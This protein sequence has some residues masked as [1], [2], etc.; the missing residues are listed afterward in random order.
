MAPADAASTGRPV[1]IINSATS[2]RCR[3]YSRFALFLFSDGMDYRGIGESR[4][5][6]LRDFGAGWIDWGALDFEAVLRHAER[7]YSDRSI[8][9]VGHS[10][11]GVMIGLARSNH[12]VRRAFTVG[13]QYAIGPTT[14]PP[15]ACG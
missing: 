3:Y 4:P 7:A 15:S 11:G 14:R 8:H 1:T 6:T 12:L 9:V 5:A 13:A 10:I 2:V